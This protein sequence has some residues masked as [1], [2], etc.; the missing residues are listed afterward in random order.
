MSLTCKVRVLVTTY[1]R[2]SFYILSFENRKYFLDIVTT[3]VY[4]KKRFLMFMNGIRQHWENPLY[5]ANL[6]AG[7]VCLITTNVTHPTISILSETKK[8]I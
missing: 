8:D 3:S 7:I 1:K 2:H 4:N 6:F 5:A